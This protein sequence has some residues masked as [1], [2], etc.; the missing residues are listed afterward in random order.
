[1]QTPTGYVRSIPIGRMNKGN[2]VALLDLRTERLQRIEAD[3]MIDPV[4]RMRPSAAERNDSH[5]QFAGLTGCKIAGL[6]RFDRQ[7][8]RRTPEIGHRALDEIRRAAE[9][10]HHFSEAFER[11]PA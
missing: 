7:D 9:R 10:V 3:P 5:A 2:Q 1:M 11:R 8:D 6:L 4:I